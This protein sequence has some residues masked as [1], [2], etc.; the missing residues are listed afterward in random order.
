MAIR[1]LSVSRPKCTKKIPAR[2]IN[3]PYSAPGSPNVLLRAPILPGMPFRKSYPFFPTTYPA[4]TW[5]L[6]GSYPVRSRFGHEPPSWTEG[7]TTEIQTR[8]VI[9]TD[10]LPQNCGRRDK[11]IAVYKQNSQTFSIFALSVSYS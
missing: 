9:K 2:H 7:G 3:R 1:F 10:V 6:P 8:R 5:H 11:K 4:P